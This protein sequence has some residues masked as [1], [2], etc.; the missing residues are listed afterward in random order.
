MSTYDGL[1]LEERRTFILHQL[2]QHGRVSV[3]DLSQNLK[4]STVT[5][6]QDLQ[7]LEESGLIK[8]TYGGA[9]LRQASTGSP[10]LSFEIRLKKNRAEK[11]ALANAA[12]GLVQEGY[13]VALDASTTAFAIAQRLRMFDNLVILTNSLM[14]A[15]QFVDCPSIEVFMPS[16]KLRS[17]SVSL[18]GRPDTLPNVNIT[19]GFFGSHGLTLEAGI[20]ELSQEEAAM[21][22]A[23]MARCAN[24]VVVVDSSKWGL[25]APHTYS[26]IRGV[27]RIL[28]TELA[29]KPMVIKMRSAGVRVDT[30]KV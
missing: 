10:E 12:V 24:R 20:M 27:E 15:H 29:P 13:G 3:K 1:F 28:T 25:I 16:G 2:N 6:R 5:I 23:I 22:Q 19:L 30:V 26:P 9:M 17:D 11:E 21:K 4:V 14:V 18:V 7:A 8:R